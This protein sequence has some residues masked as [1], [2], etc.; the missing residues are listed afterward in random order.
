MKQ[1]HFSHPGAILKREWL[2]EMGIKPG[3]LARLIGV[4]RAR[5]KAIIDGKR[6]ITADTAIRFARFFSTSPELWMNLQSHYNLE[7]A[8]AEMKDEANHITPYAA[9]IGD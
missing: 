5:I 3:T 7:L 1:T 8:D 9:L 2:D 4:D 6:D